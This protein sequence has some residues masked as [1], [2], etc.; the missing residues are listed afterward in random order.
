MVLLQFKSS[1]C[2]AYWLHVS[3]TTVT[4][5]DYSLMMS[6]LNGIVMLI[7]K[8]SN[9]PHLLVAITISAYENTAF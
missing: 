1:F 6:N 8:W 4:S 3:S 5:S 7:F 2:F 9:L